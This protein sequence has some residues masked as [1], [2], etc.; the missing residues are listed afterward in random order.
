MWTD[1]RLRC[2][3]FAYELDEEILSFSRGAG[4]SELPEN[5]FEPILRNPSGR[6]REEACPALD[7]ADALSHADRPAR[8]LEIG[9]D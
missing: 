6:I 2:R 4:D 7:S 1:G 9:K 8:V 5:P 3:H